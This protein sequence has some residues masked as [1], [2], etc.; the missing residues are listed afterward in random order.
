MS[1]P[2]NHFLATW[3]NFWVFIFS[4]SVLAI[5]HFSGFPAIILLFTA[6]F[7]II[8][9]GNDKSNYELNRNEI[10]FIILIIFFWLLSLT[11]TFFQPEGLEY[12]NTRMAL[13]AMDNPMRWLLM[14]P[15]FFLLRRYKLDW[16][17][18]SIGLSIGVFIA[19]GIASYEVL[20]FRLFKG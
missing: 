10:I 19:V 14:L 16:R 1:R 5:N 15:I 3:I 13:K 7:V 17:I 9:K 20:F 18:I 4:I 6:I 2:P 8:S 11:N 12:E